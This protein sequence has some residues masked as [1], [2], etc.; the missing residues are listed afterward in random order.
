MN[1]VNTTNG[2][3]SNSE[4][5]TTTKTRT[6]PQNNQTTPK[7]INN[8][9]DF[10]IK[11]NSSDLKVNQQRNQQ[12][13]NQSN[14]LTKSK[15]H[16]E[17]QENESN[18][19]NKIACSNSIESK[20]SAK[21]IGIDLS[22]S[23]DD[24]DDSSNS[25][26]SSSSSSNS[27]SSS[28][29]SDDDSS[30]S[31][32]SSDSDESDK[33]PSAQEVKSTLLQP[34]TL[35]IGTKQKKTSV[36]LDEVK[37]K[38]NQF[39]KICDENEIGQVQSIEMKSESEK[40]VVDEH[41]HSN[42]LYEAEDEEEDEESTTN[43]ITL[44]GLIKTIVSPNKKSSSSSSSTS[45]SSA[46]NSNASSTN[47]SPQLPSFSSEVLSK[48]SLAMPTTKVLSNNISS[49]NLI[50][51]QKNDYEGNENLVETCPSSTSSTNTR[52]MDDVDD[53]KTT[54]GITFN[55]SDEEIGDD[56]N[57]S[58]Q[59]MQIVNSL[60]QTGVLSESNNYSSSAIESSSSTTLNASKVLNTS[61]NH[62][63]TLLNLSLSQL[64]D[65][66][67]NNSL[68]SSN[69]SPLKTITKSPTDNKNNTTKSNCNSK[70]NSKSNECLSNLKM[71]CSFG[72]SNTTN[73]PLS[74]G[75]VPTSLS[76]FYNMDSNG[77]NTNPTLNNEQEDGEID[78]N[79][80]S[81]NSNQQDEEAKHTQSTELKTK[82]TTDSHNG[83]NKPSTRKSESKKQVSKVR[84]EEKCKQESDDEDE[85]KEELE[86][87]M[88]SNNKKKKHRSNEKETSI[89]EKS[90]PSSASSTTSS[91]DL[92]KQL[93][94]ETKNIEKSSPL[95]NKQKLKTKLEEKNLDEYS[96]LKKTQL[97]SSRDLVLGHV[98]EEVLLK[99]LK[100]S[101]ESKEHDL[102]LN[103]QPSIINC[104]D[105]I[106]ESNSIKEK[107][108][109]VCNNINKS[110]NN[111]VNTNNMNNM[112]NLP[113]STTIGDQIQYSADGRPRLIVSIEL[114][115][116]KII[117]F[118]QF[119]NALPNY[120]TTAD[121]TQLSNN[122]MDNNLSEMNYESQMTPTTLTPS[123]SNKSKKQS[124]KANQEDYDN[125][126]KS[127][128]TSSSSKKENKKYL[129]DLNENSKSQYKS[130]SNSNSS[131]KLNEAVE[132]DKKKVIAEKSRKR[133]STLNEDIELNNL[134]STSKKQKLSVQTSSSS[135]KVSSS[136]SHSSSSSSSSS[137]GNGEPSKKPSASSAVSNVNGSSSNNKSSSSVQ[138]SS[139]NLGNTKSASM[140]KSLSATPSP[141][142][143]FAPYLDFL[144]SQIEEQELHLRGKQKK[145]EADH[146]KDKIKRTI[147]YMEAVCYF[148]L[149]AISQ[150]RLK[151]TVNNPSSNTSYLDLLN[152][153]YNLLK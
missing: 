119:N 113:T 91:V 14:E 121:S 23:S 107:M 81:V 17:I 94:S 82:T 76:Q 47:T 10:S 115:L 27:S 148:C 105:T 125:S 59:N 141:S 13:Q 124:S 50:Y 135:S 64:S 12:K 18:N 38:L 62:D 149:C 108:S 3:K 79:V 15:Q 70:S 20:E 93:N 127:S 72:S 11:S 77:S 53:E 128:S 84:H 92:N 89:K 21:Q 145:H 83:T 55:L 153:T 151:K 29:S 97:A 152:E 74:A 61:K 101:L 1:T 37:K 63:N 45:Q 30:S 39:S 102:L 146:E 34:C 133:S 120:A 96:L 4:S 44:E 43:N 46:S 116:L 42:E 90:S 112:N 24:D 67:L 132:S 104:N 80:P 22:S 5:A 48:S 68:I 78:E 123:F 85:F 58:N 114:D 2:K 130:S 66:T 60:Q 138:S 7:N 65:A 52:R 140:N 57:A 75:F 147:S 19:N 122:H 117:N 71:E 54:T 51:S 106:H 36:D 26:S 32:S 129:S 150:Y 35:E 88:S 9:H 100:K 40:S 6:T 73:P 56:S 143:K 99:K 111:T 144:N 41:L 98:Q 86:E 110:N 49:K 118:N 28:S 16:D 142:Q 31:N 95:N 134:N 126:E 25:S 87:I 103:H 139:N 109:S 137:H 69:I 136:S 8:N 131:S 33:E